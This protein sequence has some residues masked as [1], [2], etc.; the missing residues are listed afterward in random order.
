MVNSQ[1][2]G[3]LHIAGE[4]INDRLIGLLIKDLGIHGWQAPVLPERAEDIRR[5]PNTGSGTVKIFVAPDFCT[6]LAYPHRQVAIDPHRHARRNSG[7]IRFFELFCCLPLQ[8][9]I[10]LYAFFMLFGKLCHRFIVEIAPV[11][12]EY[13]P[14]PSVFTLILQIFLHSIVSG[15][16]LKA[17]TTS[18]NEG[19]KLT[20]LFGVF[21]QICVVIL[22]KQAVQCSHFKLGHQA[23]VNILH[24]SRRLEP[25]LKILSVHHRLDCSTGIF[26]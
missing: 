8:E 12:R 21:L 3:R 26:G 9:H 13:R 17:F 20:V 7:L 18:L 4:Q 25:S 23:V 24:A 15:L 19:L 10:K 14:A 2:A 16:H 11:F 1:S 6:A 22:I 5:C